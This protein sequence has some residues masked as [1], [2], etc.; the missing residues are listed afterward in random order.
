MCVKIPSVHLL[1]VVFF[2]LFSVW[3]FSSVYSLWALA[4]CSVAVAI[5]TNMPSSEGVGVGVYSDLYTQQAQSGVF[6][7]A[8]VFE[9]SR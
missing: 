6:K 8:D 9:M 2:Y 1:N 3:F 7:V 4:V 5:V